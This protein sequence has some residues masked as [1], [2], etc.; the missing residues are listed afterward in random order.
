MVNSGT[1]LIAALSIILFCF[2]K[3]T[4]KRVYQVSKVNNKKYLVRSH[5]SSLIQLKSAN[6]LASLS[7]KKN[8]LC[9]FLAVNDKYKNHYGVKRLLSNRHVKLEELSYEYNNE[10][11]YSINKGERIGM[12]LRKK[13][14]TIENENT[15]FFVLM[16]ELAHIMSIKYAHDDEF[17]DNFA[18]LIKAGTECGVYKYRD[19]G[20][21]PT[22]YCGHHI[23]HTPK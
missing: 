10:A 13:N 20:N 11:A 19:F 8:K 5:N 14:G 15:M 23:T 9:D 7:K 3:T 18:L 22:T 2:G 16:H 12:C 4:Y 17:W 21:N 6:L 1:I